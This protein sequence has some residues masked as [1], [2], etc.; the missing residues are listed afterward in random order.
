MSESEVRLIW[1]E[2]TG[3]LE[4]MTSGEKKIAMAPEN[5][6]RARAGMIFDALSLS[7]ETSVHYRIGEIDISV[8]SLEKAMR[9]S[10]RRRFCRAK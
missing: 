10:N 2:M 5:S 4:W 7:I 3:H 1:R 6:V 9:S 8:L